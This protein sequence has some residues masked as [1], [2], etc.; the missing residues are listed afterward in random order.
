M[1]AEMNSFP[2]ATDSGMLCRLPALQLS[3]LKTYSLFHEYALYQS[4]EK[5]IPRSPRQSTKYHGLLR[6]GAPF[7][8]ALFA[9]Y[10]STISFAASRICCTVS[11]DLPMIASASGMFGVI[12]VVWGINNFFK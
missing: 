5:Q 8:T 3:Q 11:I 2:V 4:G 1:V 9:P 10:T 7:T 6:S 12:T